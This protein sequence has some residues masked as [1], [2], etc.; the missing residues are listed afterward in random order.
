LARSELSRPQTPD[1]D[2]EAE[3]RLYA[4]L[5]PSVLW[6]RTS[7]RR[8]R[9]EARTRFFDD[10]VLTAVTSGV[11]QVVIVGAGYDGRALRFRCPGVHFFELDHPAT[12][13]D[14]RRRVEDLGVPLDDVTFASID[15]MRERIGAVLAEAG[16]RPDE[17][18]LFL[19]EGLLLYLTTPVVESLLGD[20][21]AG[22]AP[23]SR[24]AL[25]IREEIPGGSALTAT[26]GWARRG[27][28][29]MI[30]EPRRS[31]FELGEFGQLLERTGWTVVREVARDRRPGDRRRRLLLAAEAQ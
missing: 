7:R 17:R 27:L 22:A 3:H 5:R 1:G 23:A 2:P 31:S 15:L 10:E 28:L 9:M 6:P 24:L 8:R 19:C 30:G 4:T 18:S 13:S 29:R 12:Q 11:P 26:R 20:L 25:S 21:R 14:K 16:H